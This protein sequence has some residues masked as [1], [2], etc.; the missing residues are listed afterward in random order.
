MKEILLK[1]LKLYGQLIVASFMCIM[2]VITFNLIGTSFFTKNIGYT[3]FGTL[4][5]Q[6]TQTEL[7]THY[8]SDGEDDKKQSY[9]DDGY[10][11]TEV[12][13]RS[14]I[15]KS[16]GIIWDCFTEILL[17]TLFG[18]FVYNTLWNIG[19]KDN[20]LVHIGAKKEDKFK[21]LKIGTITTLPSI[22]LLTVLTIGKTSFA[23]DIA[24]ALYGF[25]NSHLY[26]AVYLIS[27][28]GGHFGSLAVWQILLFY[29][30][31]AF[32]PLL[33]HIAY[34]LGYKSIL[35]SEKLIYKKK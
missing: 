8:Y 35:V 28:G 31:L 6:E 15:K 22:V 3:V 16:T 32:V 4:E 2:L 10:T 33:A 25:L 20:N 17:L 11:L 7:Y 29:V 26:E 34:I 14:K 9:I 27:G 21:G 13:V 18:V 24:V 1:S 12:S 19:F 23:K 5:G 30:M